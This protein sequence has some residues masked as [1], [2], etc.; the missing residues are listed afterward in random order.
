MKQVTRLGQSCAKHSPS[1]A[2]SLGYQVKKIMG[3]LVSLKI[4]DKVDQGILIN[5]L[6]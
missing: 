6:M 2:M 3:N 5:F 4:F 1:A